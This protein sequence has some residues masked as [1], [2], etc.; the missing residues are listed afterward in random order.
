[1]NSLFSRRVTPFEI[2][3]KASAGE[4]MNALGDTSFQARNL[5]LAT[6]IWSRMLRDDV[7]IFMGLAGAMVPAGMRRVV[8]YLVENRLIDCLVSTGANLY[9][10]LYETLGAPHWKTDAQT[11]DVLLGRIR[12]NRF[13]DVLAPEDDFFSG[14][15]F[16]TEFSRTLEPDKPYT[17]REFLNLLGRSLQ[18]VAREEGILTSAARAGVPIFCPAIGDSAIG[19]GIA[20]ARAQSGHRLVFDLIGDVLE[21]SFLAATSRGTGVIYVGGGTPKNY[22]QQAEVTTYVF[23]RELEGHKYGIQLTMDNPQWGG[24]SGCTFEEA[25]SWRKIAPEANTVTV[26]VEATVALPLIVSALADG[27]GEAIRGRHLPD[28]RLEGVPGR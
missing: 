14:Q 13:Y 25:Q 15:Q 20:E 9:H 21:I 24:L 26:N 7:T 2:R 1:V 4:L 10:D 8:T 16:V 6:E 5:G 12:A 23:G 3:E 18:V 22:I 28:L 11:D 19:I 27:H 17:T